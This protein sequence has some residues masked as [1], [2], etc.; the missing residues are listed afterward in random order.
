MEPATEFNFLV[1]RDAH[2]P[3]AAGFYVSGTV[4]G[5][6]WEEPFLYVFHQFPGCDH[7]KLHGLF[8]QKQPEFRGYVAGEEELRN[9][10]PF[11]SRKTARVIAAFETD[12]EMTVINA[13]ADESAA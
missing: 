1:G 12:R 4:I 9:R 11:C 10:R 2:Y 7:V 8:I 3:K 13:S 5:Y 6:G